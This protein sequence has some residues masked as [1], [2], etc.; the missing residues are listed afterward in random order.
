MPT[1]TLACVRE[2]TPTIQRRSEEIENARRL[3][4]DLVDELKTTGAF[5]M[6][7]PHAAGGDELPLRE[8]VQVIEELAAA[9]G[10]TGWT[11]MIGGGSPLVFGLLPRAGWDQVYAD[12]P[13]VIGAGALAPKGRAVPVADG[14]CI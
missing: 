8:S 4:L 1:S 3:P 2:L 10:S 6:L 5:R 14:Y 7:V 13:D 9:D 12:G 11:V